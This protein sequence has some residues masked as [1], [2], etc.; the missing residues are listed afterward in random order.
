MLSRRL[1]LNLAAAAALSSAAASAQTFALQEGDRV[2]FYG[3]SITDQR[4][5]TTFAETYVVTRFPKLN[6]SFVHSGWGG[7]RVTGGGGG[8]VDVRLWRDVL[9]YNPTVVTI[10]LGMNDGH[11]RAFD[12][13]FFDEFSAGYKHI[14]DTLTRQLPGVRI[15]AI[16]P[17][18]YDDVTR[19]PL[20]EGGYNQV[21]LKYGESLRQMAADQKLAIADLNT[22]MV[23]AL[24]KANAADPATAA[25]ILP[26]RVHPAA[27]GHLLMAEALLK[28][29]NAP[30]LVTDVEL[31][32]GRKE[33]IRQRNTHIADL[34]G[35]KV[36]SWTQ[37]D[38]ALP[39]PIDMRDPLVALAVRSS[40]VVEALDRQ[41]LQVRG[42]P[43]GHY[44]L[45]IDGETAGSFTADQLAA[46]VNL[47]TLPTPMMRQAAQVHALTLRHNNIHYTRWRQVQVLMEKDSTPHLLS[48]LQ[49]LDELELDVLKQQRAAAQPRPRH[50]ELAP[51]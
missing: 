1:L 33:P 41:P 23:A 49:A 17:S 22:D 27:G 19:P 30:A 34:Q 28:S 31:D 8:P 45:K 14:V 32:A 50:Y 38:D 39:M 11:Y 43:A 40:D 3:D 44:T 36:I 20:F 26:D 15:T 13:T 4:L 29:W 7:D 18:P 12:Q 10:M 9:P 35:G 48:S 47:A 2:V 24:Q 16:V 51:E 37:T 6:V 21:L 46:G 25:R 5:Y 42:L